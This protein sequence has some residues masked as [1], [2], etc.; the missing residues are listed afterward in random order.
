[1]NANW[2]STAD[3]L[4]PKETPVLILFSNE[5]IRIG[6]IRWEYPT[7]EDTYNAFRYWDDPADDGKDWEWLDITHWQALPALPTKEK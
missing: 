6:E 7:Y 3:S 5:T 1:M 2:I 4:P